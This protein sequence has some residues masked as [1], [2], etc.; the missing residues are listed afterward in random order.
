MAT[1]RSCFT[2]NE[3]NTQRL[4]G[5]P[6]RTPYVKDSINNY[7]VHGQAGAVNPAATG[8]KVAPHYRV[9][10]R[11][12]SETIR[13]RLTN[14]YARRDGRSRQ[15]GK[16]PGKA[17]DPFG[18]EFDEILEP[19]VKPR[20]RRVLRRSHSR[21]ARR[22]SGQRHAA[23]PGRHALEQTV[24]PLRR[25]QW[26]EERGSD[27]FKA[28][29]KQAPRNEHWHHMYNGDVISMPDK[30]EYPWYAAWD[31]AFHVIVAHARRSGLR[32][33]S[34]TRSCCCANAT[35]TP[36]ARFRPTNGTSATSIRRCMRGRPFSPTA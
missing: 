25:R 24:L 23:G 11:R 27:P 10:V 15:N 12:A 33:R 9:T 35:C 8:T 34:A 13:L 2:E 29:R 14:A 32:Q 4:F 16:E 22:R 28:K 1:Y 26:L 17:G 20:G 6:N 31:L 21:Q 3:T 19:S 18:R 5:V 7:V 30:W 36:T